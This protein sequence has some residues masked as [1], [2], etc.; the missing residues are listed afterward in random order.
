MD[1][2]TWYLL[3]YRQTN[4]SVIKLNHLLL[5]SLYLFTRETYLKTAGKKICVF[6]ILQ[7]SWFYNRT[8]LLVINN[9]LGI[10]QDFSDFQRTLARK[11]PFS[12]HLV[13]GVI[14]KISVPES[15]ELCFVC[16]QAARL[17]RTSLQLVIIIFFIYLWT[18]H[19]AQPPA[20]RT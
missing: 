3:K 12:Y 1:D 6:Y 14:W 9:Q 19:V 18:R 16:T 10:Y 17:R 13:I 5:Q 8:E 15:R 11:N 7:P 20:T 2:G 4:F